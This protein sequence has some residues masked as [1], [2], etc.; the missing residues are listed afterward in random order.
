V[1]SVSIVASEARIVSGSSTVSIETNVALSS[2]SSS[3]GSWAATLSER[4]A[5]D[6][7]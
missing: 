6:S 7:R 1:A 3:S 2:L 4:S 5:S